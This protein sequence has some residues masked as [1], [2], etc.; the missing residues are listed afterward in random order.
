MTRGD[1]FALAAAISCIGIFATAGSLILPVLTLNL[2]A[3]GYSSALIGLFGANIGLGAVIGTPFA[4]ALVR[5]WGAGNVLFMLLLVIV[6]ANLSYKLFDDSLAAW[7]AIYFAACLA[8]GL[9]FVVAETV[10][11]A[12][13]PPARRSL[14]L[15]LY[16]TGFSLGFAAGPVMLRFTGIDG[17]T[18]FVVAAGLAATAAALVRAANI[19]KIAVPET[20]KSEFPRMFALAPLPFICAFSLGATEMAVYDLLPVYARKLEYSVADAVFLI[21]IFSVGALLVQ[22]AVGVVADKFNVRRT[23][24]AAAGCGVLGAVA[25][26]FFLGGGAAAEWNWQNFPR[27][28]C[29]GIWGGLLMAVYPLGLAQMARFFAAGKLAAANALFGFSYGAGALF[30]PAAT[31][32]AM[33]ISPNGIAP[34]LAFFAALPLAAIFLRRKTAA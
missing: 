25:L 9:V 12:L 22:P 3:R 32:A 6:A 5:R 24:A 29:F 18:P 14:I 15:G 20:G 16:A 2:E 26:P 33:D 21:T 7:F 17:W 11:T 8:L 1:K 10:I 27:M 19:R 34:A 28:A 13:A 31:G 4:P 23:L 30:G